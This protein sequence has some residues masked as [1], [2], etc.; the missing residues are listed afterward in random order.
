ME[1]IFAG[2]S[3]YGIGAL[4]SIQKY[5]DKVYLIKDNP[6]EILRERRAC[7]PIIEDFNDS[8]CNIVF[9]GGYTKIITAEQISKKTY[10]NVHGSLLPK[11]RGMHSVFWA[12]MNGEEQL[13]VTY[14]LVNEY[15]DAGDIL[16]QFEI[17]YVGQ[18]VADILK[19]I[20]ELIEIQSGELLYH[21]ILGNI[22]PIQQDDSKA[23]YGAK[24]NMMDCVIDFN[25][26]NELLNRYFL[27]LTEP[28]PLPMLKINGELYEVLDHLILEKNYFGPLGRAVY[29]DS[30]GVW[31]KIKE[32]FI[33]ISSVRK[34]GDRISC[35][36]KDLVKI[37]YR[38]EK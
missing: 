36:L 14:H 12:I 27:A 2:G 11:Y 13:G 24:R 8:D 6:E 17:D 20:D 10:I 3:H 9:L 5:F 21:Y 16:A 4:H 19:T 18:T 15:I 22:K 30:K 25:W 32:G 31:I 28:Y 26:T 34:V 33:V 29:I 1:I 38:F 7:D 23:T 37:G 35:Q